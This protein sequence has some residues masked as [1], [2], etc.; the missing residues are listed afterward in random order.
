MRLIPRTGRK[1]GLA[2]PKSGLV[3]APG[4]GGLWSQQP[5][6]WRLSMLTDGVGHS[7]SETRAKHLLGHEL[8]GPWRMHSCGPRRPRA[9]SLARVGRG[10]RSAASPLAVSPETLSAVSQGAPRPAAG[11]SFI[12]CSD[13]YRRGAGISGHFQSP[14]GDFTPDTSLALRLSVQLSVLHGPALPCS[15]P[16]SQGEGCEEETV[17]GGAEG[18]SLSQPPAFTLVVWAGL[19]PGNAKGHPSVGL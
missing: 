1:G 15:G 13:S 10:L 12:S 19:G 4:W 3:R 14:Q 8:Q 5:V 2:L 6:T 16:R 11:S 9:L 7:H 18:G 17:G